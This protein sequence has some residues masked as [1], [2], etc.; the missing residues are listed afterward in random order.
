MPAIEATIKS[1]GATEAVT[2]EVTGSNMSELISSI[3]VVKDSLNDLLTAI[4][5]R[6]A[7]SGSARK[8]RTEEG[9]VHV[10]ARSNKQNPCCRSLSK[11]SVSVF[12]YRRGGS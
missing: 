7:S 9:K 4:V 3:K 8:E 10:P 1:Q 5:V 11:F 2:Q 6:D 12:S